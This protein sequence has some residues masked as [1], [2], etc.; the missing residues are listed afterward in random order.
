MASLSRRPV[1]PA[2]SAPSTASSLSEVISITTRVAPSGTAS[3]SARVASIAAGVRQIEVH[4][5]DI[6]GGGA[7]RA[8]GLVG[9]RRLG[10][11]EHVFLLEQDPEGGT[12][13]ALPLRDDH[14][15][16][17]V[18]GQGER[19]HRSLLCGR[20]QGTLDSRSLPPS[21]PWDLAGVSL[22]ATPRAA[23]RSALRHEL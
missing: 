4:E 21:P 13:E 10:G 17:S 23:L 15:Q 18:V 1:A 2:R 9:G 7:R 5:D 20:S 12:H 6:G 19:F 22:P 8:H 16:G 3:R 11:D 14:T